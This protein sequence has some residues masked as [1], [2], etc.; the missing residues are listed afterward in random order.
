MP[1]Q[2]RSRSL[3]RDQCPPIASATTASYGDVTPFADSS[4]HGANS[5]PGS[6]VTIDQSLTLQDVGIIFRSVGDDGNFAVYSD[7]G[8]TPDQMLD[9]TG[10]FS[11]TAIGDTHDAFKNHATLTAGNYWLMAVFNGTASVGHTSNTG[12]TVAYQRLGDISALPATFGP[13]SLYPGQEFNYYVT[14]DTVSSVPEPD[15]YAMLLAGFGLAG[16]M[17][18]SRKSR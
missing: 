18:R 7:A 15:S 13:A 16:L 11:V 2:A 9:S 1:G 14:G 17:I 10:V 8:G 12:A 6:A 4:V 5:L 3:A